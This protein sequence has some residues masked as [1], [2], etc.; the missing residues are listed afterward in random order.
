M[1]GQELRQ[2]LIKLNQSQ[3]GLAKKIGVDERT[4]RKWVGG[5]NL[6]PDRIVLMVK[7]VK[8]GWTW[9]EVTKLM[10]LHTFD[11]VLDIAMKRKRR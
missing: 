7:M 5:N 11:D 10:R 2:Q 1:T 9:E 3:R 6:V 8:D 4:V